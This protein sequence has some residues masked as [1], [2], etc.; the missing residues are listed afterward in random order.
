VKSVE[1]LFNC[2]SHLTTTL[3]TEIAEV[4][5]VVAA[6]PWQPTFSLATGGKTLQH[7]AAYNKALAQDF[8]ALG[9]TPQPRLL[10]SPRLIGDLQKGLVFVEVQF[11]NSATLY[12]DYYKFEFG[13]AN[14]LLSLAV[15]IVPEDPLAFF[16]TRKPASI[17]NMADFPLADRCLSVLPIRVPTWLI[18]LKP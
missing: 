2:G 3:A 5:K 11:G 12:R 13:L 17:G 14:G 16:P 9:W 4:R 15:L 8:I 10:S 18:G 1:K 7:Q 6:L